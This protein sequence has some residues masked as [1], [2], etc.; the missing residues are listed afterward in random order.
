MK[1]NQRGAQRRRRRIRVWTLPQARAAVPYLSSVL[2]SLREHWLEAV[3][4]HRTAERLAR[5]PGRPDRAALT[6]IDDARRAADAADARYREAEDELLA[7]DVYPLDPVGGQVLIPFVAGDEL[8]W[9]VFDL[10]EPEPIRSWRY[11]TDPLEARRPLDEA[12]PEP[13]DTTW[14]A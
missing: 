6:A 5:Q 7:L 4:Q 14:L 2:R 12:G 3:A 10:F 1:R 8:A 13:S 9:Y 11:H